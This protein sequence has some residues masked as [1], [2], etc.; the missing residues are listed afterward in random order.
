MEFI[1]CNVLLNWT[2]FVINVW[3]LLVIPSGTMK[4]Q[5]GRLI[6]VKWTERICVRSRTNIGQ[7]KANIGQGK[8][9]R[10]RLC[11]KSSQHRTRK[12]QKSEVVSE[13]ELTS[14]KEN[15]KERGC[16]RSRANIG[17]GQTKK[18]R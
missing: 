13:V 3:W 11:P 18:V 12:S 8:A 17:Q 4:V 16:V 5:I 2:E 10:A 9:K 1:V 14:D 7:G 6:N 15:P